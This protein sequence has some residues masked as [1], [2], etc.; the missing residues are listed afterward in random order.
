MVFRFEKRVCVFVVDILGLII[1]F[2]LIVF[3][4][5]NIDDSI[6]LYI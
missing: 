2:I 3:G 4:L 6:R 1:I 5:V